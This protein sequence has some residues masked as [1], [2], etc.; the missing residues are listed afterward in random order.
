M[1]GLG[2]ISDCSQREVIDQP[3]SIRLVLT[4]ANMPRDGLVCSFSLPGW[5]FQTCS[6]VCS[7]SGVV[8]AIGQRYVETC[9]HTA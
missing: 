5:K 4:E 7:F 8:A 3:E 2:V 9:S 1:N 6:S